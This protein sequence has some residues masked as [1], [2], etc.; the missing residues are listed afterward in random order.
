MTGPGH[1]GLG[2]LVRGLSLGPES[3]VIIAGLFEMLGE[4]RFVYLLSTYCVPNIVVASS[5]Y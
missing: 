1:A 5:V 2:T 4:N 3:A